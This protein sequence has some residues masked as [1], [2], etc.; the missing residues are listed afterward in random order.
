[1]LIVCFFVHLLLKVCG[2]I[3]FFKTSSRRCLISD[4]IWRRL[5]MSV[6]TNTRGFWHHIPAAMYC[7]HENGS[8]YFDIFIAGNYRVFKL[9][10]FCLFLFF[11]RVSQD[12][13]LVAYSFFFFTY[14]C[15]CCNQILPFSFYYFSLFL[16]LI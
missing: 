6:I 3:S 1:M 14:S 5:P 11:S 10:S 16:T 13:I 2:S 8:I 15:C 7:F 9:S 12:V 4:D